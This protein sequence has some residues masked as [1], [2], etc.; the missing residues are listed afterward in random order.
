MNLQTI[1]EQLQA[2]NSKQLSGVVKMASDEYGYKT[3]NVD[4]LN[5]MVL[6]EFIAKNNASE[7]I[8]WAKK[9]YFNNY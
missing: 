9:Y 5:L 4:C 6:A 2:L 7:I 3:H 1:K 8:V